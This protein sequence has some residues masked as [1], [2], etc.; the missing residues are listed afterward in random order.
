MLKQLAIGIVIS[1]LMLG[2][3]SI[4][5]ADSNSS[6]NGSGNIFTYSKQV[7]G[8][9]SGVTYG[10]T[11]LAHS[12]NATGYPLSMTGTTTTKTNTMT[13]FNGMESG[14]LLL[15]T[16][17]AS[18]ISPISTRANVS[19]S[20]NLALNA[21]LSEM[22][23]DNLDIGD[24]PYSISSNNWVVYQLETHNL[25]GYLVSNGKVA[26]SSVNNITFYNNASASMGATL[27]AGFISRGNA[28]TLLEKYSLDHHEDKFA[29]NITTGNVNGS[30]L[31]FVLNKTNGNITNFTSVLSSRE[32]FSNINASGNG[33]L[34]PQNDL[35]AFRASVITV[36]GIFVYSNGSKMYAIHNNPT[37]Q[38]NFLVYNGTVSFTLGNGLT[39][40]NFTTPGNDEQY[41]ASLLGSN[42]TYDENNSFGLN[43]EFQA[44]HNTIA[45]S[46]ANF[47]AFLLVSNANTTISGNTLTFTSLNN[48][49]A[50]VSFLAPPGLQ[51]L[52]NTLQSRL[53][54]AISNGKIA[55]EI[56]ISNVNSTISNLTMNLN[57]SVNFSI[58]SMNAGKVS[59]RIAS[60]EHHGANLAI[61]ISNKVISNNSNNVYVYLDGT[62]VS[63]SS[64][65]GVINST[66]D[67]NAYYTAVHES[68]GVLLIVHIPHFSNHTLVVSSAQIPQTGGL[69]SN[70]YVYAAI[71]GVVAAIAAIGALS[72]VKKRRK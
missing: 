53:H 51:E 50:K 11:L 63:S 15:A 20:F 19:L 8:N 26:T 61:F 18:G 3:A 71:G 29:Y 13:I 65:N 14:S 52:N 58:S 4:A 37:L 35:S 34:V 40:T 45:I 48:S 49:I 21:S 56:S 10:S 47:S 33:T 64:F 54:Y 24:N 72:I 60:L 59:F 12:V 23:I 55:S 38:S 46:G 70:D 22:G 6:D 9:L 69:S 32:I 44:G 17:H 68:T 1:M 7:N 43:H 25:T 39:A 28:E 2:T 57:A 41:N 42:M 30:F 27:V 16:G 36:G 67:V 66:S 5:L 31:T 62:Q